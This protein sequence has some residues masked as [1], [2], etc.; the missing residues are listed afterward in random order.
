MNKENECGKVIWVN[1]NKPNSWVCFRKPVN[2]ECLLDSVTIKIAVDTKYWF[3]INGELVVFEGGLNRESAPGCGYYDEVDITNHLKLGTNTLAFMVWYWGNGGRNNTNSGTAGILFESDELNLHSDSFVKAKKHSGYAETYEPY[4]SYLYGGH[5]IGYQADNDMDGWEMPQFCDD[6]WQFAIIKDKTAWGI[7]YK[8]PIPLI[9]FSSITP[10]IKTEKNNKQLVAYLPYA[11]HLTPFIKVIAR[12]GCYIDIHTDRYFVN[13]GPGDETNTYRGHRA[14]YCTKE[15]LQEFECL[16]WLFG[17]QVLYTMDDS[18]EIVEVGYRESGYN[19]NITGDFVCDNQLINRLI[20]KCK[21]TLYVCMRDNY[22]DCPDRERGQWIGDVSSQIPQTFYCLDRNADLLS[23]KAI[24]DFIGL[25][26]GDV[27][28]GNVPG[29][30]FTELPSQS[31]NAISE[32]GMIMEYVRFSGDTSVFRLSY[33]AIKRYLLLWDIKEDGL[34]GKRMG[35]WYWFDHLNNVD[36]K[37]LENCWYALSLKSAITIAEDL[38]YKCDVIIFENLLQSLQQHF[39]QAFWKSDSYR[40]IPFPDDRANAL[41]IL[42]GFSKIQHKDALLR[43]FQNSEFSTPYMEYY[44][45]EALFRLGFAQSAINRLL[46][47]Y[48]PLITNENS[49]LWEDFSILGT[50]NHAWT[51]GA[52][53]VCYK[54][55]AGIYPEKYGMESVCILPL[56]TSINFIHATMDTYYGKLIVNVTYC[57]DNVKI[58]VVIPK[59]IHARIGIPANEYRS[60]WLNQIK[61]DVA[62]QYKEF[63]CV[64]VTDGVYC[65]E[66]II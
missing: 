47:R 10:Y 8:R 9:K 62:E 44:V 64:V 23:R 63:S 38:G 26:K 29:D 27:L 43:V 12:K 52:L 22:M 11:M 5:N 6:A 37:I 4:P 19:C 34:V 24:T 58:D 59:G 53:T 25:R 48:K 51:G 20:E 56:K 41:A 21:R 65:V 50:K 15:G 1:E 60:L 61:V 17:E 16:N 46:N 42:S 7:L 33:Q 13:G 66:G 18:I 2:I 28:V 32:I 31:L 54:Y 57:D 14:Q 45:L 49:T 35:N 39:E 40:N 55:L 3:Y 30:N 36:E